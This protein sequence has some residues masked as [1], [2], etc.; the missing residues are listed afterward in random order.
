MTELLRTNDAVRLSFARALLADA[1]IESVV[2]DVHASVVEGSVIAIQRRVMVDDDDA[3]RARTLLEA[4][5][6]TSHRD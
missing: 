2:L 4:A 5:G 3:V 6:I 1:G